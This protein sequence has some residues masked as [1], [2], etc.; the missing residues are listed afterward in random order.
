M[1]TPELAGR[2]GYVAQNPDHQIFNATIEAEVAFA[3]EA[4]GY[5]HAEIDARVDRALAA[6]GLDEARQH[7]P[8][9]LPRGDR[10]R[11]VIAAVLAMAPDILIFDEP[12]TGQDDQGARQILDVTRELHRA[13]KTIIVITHHLHLMPDY[14]ERVVVMGAGNVLL[15][16]PIREAYAAVDVLAKSYLTPPQVVRLYAALTEGPPVAPPLTPGELAHWLEE[17]RRVRK[18]VRNGTGRNA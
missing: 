4:Q 8:L 10:A 5:N 17:K 3:L 18:D 6:M 1:R 13:G 16:A 14:A 9:S 12:T 7:H 11:V 15:D 2:I